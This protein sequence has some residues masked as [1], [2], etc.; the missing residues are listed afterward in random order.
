M[1]K[2]SRQKL[3]ILYLAKYLMER[4]EHSLAKVP[5]TVEAS[6]TFEED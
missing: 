5:E 6:V 4:Y 1:P 2:S 3:K